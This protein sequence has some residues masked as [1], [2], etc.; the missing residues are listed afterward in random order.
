MREVY[1]LHH[2]Y[3]LVLPMH[4]SLCRQ[5]P[6]HLVDVAQPIVICISLRLVRP[7]GL[8]MSLICLL[9]SMESLAID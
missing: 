2:S 9:F 5:P 6:G 4:V 7:C 3:S 8:A 1:G